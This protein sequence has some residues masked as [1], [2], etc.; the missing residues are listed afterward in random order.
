MFGEVKKN[1]FVSLLSNYCFI[2]IIMVIRIVDFRNQSPFM[3]RQRFR[4]KV[5]RSS[6]GSVQAAL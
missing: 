1:S 6:V 4:L 3:T 5:L 2:T